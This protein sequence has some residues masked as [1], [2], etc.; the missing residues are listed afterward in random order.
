MT[1]LTDKL[2]A[3]GVHTGTQ[4]ILKPNIRNQHSIDK[5]LDG[6]FID[7]PYGEIFV[8][9]N[10]FPIEYRLGQTPIKLTSELDIL[11]SWTGLCN[12]KLLPPEAFIFIDI[13]TTGLS[14]G[15]G[16]YA[17][18]IG[19]GQYIANEFRIMQVFLREPFEEPAQL[20]AVDQYLSNAQAVVSFN[21]KAFD[22]P[23][24]ISRYT[25]HHRYHPFLNMA[26]IDLL[27]LA[28]RLWRDRIQN[29][30]LSNLEYQILGTSRT[31]ED[32]PG[33]M[34][35]SIYF[36]F[37]RDSD[38][39]PL[40]RVFYHNLM[41]VLS[42]AALLNHISGM[43]SKSMRLSEIHKS[44]LIAIA[45]I[46]EDIGDLESAIHLYN[47]A[48]NPANHSYGF[49]DNHTFFKAIDRLARIHKHEQNY[50]I[51]IELWKQAANLLQIPPCVELAKYYEHQQKDISE[52]IYWTRFALEILDKDIKPSETDS[53]PTRF[54]RD[55]YR[56]DLEHRLERLSRKALKN[57]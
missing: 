10:S 15:T 11:S 5:V 2:R 27:H 53:F 42:L 29:R 32:I 54:D 55:L 33:W 43:L 35:P 26:H 21:G 38:A 34:V 48:L 45:G 12:I 7:T 56:K 52:A 31:E 39:R 17:F 47:H 44:D 13:E 8:V 3:L 20:F 9:E 50:F 30:M 16:T 37:L 28:R 41:D 49:L 24:L 19:I 4:E 23:L 1:S 14:G 18:L 25:L 51:A 40:K 22:L 36:D 6:T 46:L 57:T